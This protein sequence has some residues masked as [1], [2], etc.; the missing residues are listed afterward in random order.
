MISTHKAVSA[1][2]TRKTPP[3]ESSSAGLFPTTTTSSD[4]GSRI[5]LAGTRVSYSRTLRRITLQRFLISKMVYQ[6]DKVTYVEL[7]TLYD[8][9]LWCDDKSL[10]DPT[11]RQCFGSFL[12]KLALILKENRLSE[13]N[14][15][16]SLRKIG[17]QLKEAIAD[18]LIPERNLLNIE[19]YC[20]GKFHVSPTRESGVPTKELPPVKVIG[21]GYRDKGSYRDPAWDGSPS[22]QELA[23]HFERKGS[24]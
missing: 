18:H 16:A 22:W 19:K 24:Q 20:K 8:N 1:S 5:S 14:I 3:K 15:E 11:F 10:S 17:T 23:T 4:S 21:R 6:P 12:E 9:F 7:L 2:S 13:K